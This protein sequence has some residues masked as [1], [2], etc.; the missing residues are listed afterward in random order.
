[1]IAKQIC[2]VYKTKVITCIHIK[3]NV[4]QGINI[5]YDI[6]KIRIIGA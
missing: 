4:I 5:N 6:I 2:N 3:I 1:M